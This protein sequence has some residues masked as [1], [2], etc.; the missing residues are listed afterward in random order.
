MCMVVLQM[1]FYG[2]YGYALLCDLKK[3]WSDTLVLMPSIEFGY[4]MLCKL[5]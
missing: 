3:I 4:L 2:E 5:F 1:S